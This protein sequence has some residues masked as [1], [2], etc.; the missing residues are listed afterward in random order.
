M[1][2]VAALYDLL[3]AGVN[4]LQGI[5]MVL[6]GV[7]VFLVYLLGIPLTI[8]AWLTFYV[9]FKVRGVSFMQPKRFAVVGICGLADTIVSALPAWI[10]AVV[11]LILTTRAEE[12]L[13]KV[14]GGSKV[15]GAMRAAEGKPG[16][17]IAAPPKKPPMPPRA[18][19]LPP[20]SDRV[21]P[22]L[23]DVRSPM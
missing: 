12:L 7:G 4:L 16:A 9:W 5:N 11:L 10:A 20:Q 17:A 2:A 3:Q 8:W 1:V 13:E 21:Q 19:Q 6:P 23:A 15:A 18:T 14:P 22:R